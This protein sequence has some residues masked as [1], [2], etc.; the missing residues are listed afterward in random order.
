MLVKL[1][2]SCKLFAC[3]DYFCLLFILIIKFCKFIDRKC[4]FNEKLQNINYHI[5]ILIS[6]KLY[7]DY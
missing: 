2:L 4:I 7:S 6:T 3:I 5:L 1:E